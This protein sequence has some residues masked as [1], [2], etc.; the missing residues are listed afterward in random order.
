MK[1]TI[2]AIAVTLTTLVPAARV[3]AEQDTTPVFDPA[4]RELAQQLRNPKT[5]PNEYWHAV[6]RCETGSNWQDRGKFAGGLGIFVGTWENYGGRQF[7][8][9]PSQATVTEQIVVAN[10]IAVFG[11]QTRHTFLTLDDRLNNRPFFRP[12]AGFFGWGCVAKHSH[13]FPKRW[14]RN[15]RP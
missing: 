7:A 4:Q 8:P 15:H 2:A 3:N 10:R 5:P 12:R 11:F 1:R 6:A 9:H 13:L 14:L